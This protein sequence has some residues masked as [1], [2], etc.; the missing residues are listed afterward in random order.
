MIALNSEKRYRVIKDDKEQVAPPK[1]KPTTPKIA[2]EPRISLW[3]L[4]C[5]RMIF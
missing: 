2:D 3:Y 5:N 1:Q 4:W